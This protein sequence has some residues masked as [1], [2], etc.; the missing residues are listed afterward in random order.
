AARSRSRAARSRTCPPSRRR[1]ADGGGSGRRRA[2]LLPELDL[3]AVAIED[4]GEIAVIFVVAAQYPDPPGFEMR[5]QRVEI[6]DAQVHHEGR[7]R[8][9]HIVGRLVERGQQTERVLATLVGP[10]ERG[11]PFAAYAEILL[12]PGLRPRR[13]ADLVKNAA[14]P[15]HPGHS[16]PPQILDSR[17]FDDGLHAAPYRGRYC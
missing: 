7:V 14:E 5:D 8:G 1:A 11:A 6:V 15:C 3:N 12:V 13:I 16:H 17:S 2:L 9:R 10:A 4:P